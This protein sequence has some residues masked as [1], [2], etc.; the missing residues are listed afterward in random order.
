MARPSASGIY[1]DIERASRFG[2]E[3]ERDGATD[4]VLDS[5]RGKALGHLHRQFGGR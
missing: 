2:M 5:G 1:V 3:A 4:G